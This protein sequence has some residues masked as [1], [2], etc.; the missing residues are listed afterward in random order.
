[1]VPPAAGHGVIACAEKA[2]VVSNPSSVMAGEGATRPDCRGGASVSTGVSSGFLSIGN[3]GAAATRR[4]R[5]E[6]P[7]R[8]VAGNVR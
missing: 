1:M 5:R 7:R 8:G 4:A 3:T 6:L 2:R